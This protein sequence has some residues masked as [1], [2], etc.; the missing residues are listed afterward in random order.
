MSI[1]LII[2]TRPTGKI[3]TIV[4][5]S[6][7]V[8]LASPLAP[9][10]FSSTAGH[11]NFSTFSRRFLSISL[12]MNR[13]RVTRIRLLLF[14]VNYFDV[15]YLFIIFPDR[16]K[17]QEHGHGPWGGRVAAVHHG[18]NQHVRQG[19]LRLG[20][21]LRFRR[22]DYAQQRVAH[23]G[24]PVHHIAAVPVVLGVLVLSVRVAV[25]IPDG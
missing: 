24:R 14:G 19:G 18:H 13:T 23:V 17:S 12:D 11:V 1:I 7:S 5:P 6:E 4:Q 3:N 22:P 20:V 21:Q 25:R 2:L 16:R 9:G 8:F 15:I 10:G